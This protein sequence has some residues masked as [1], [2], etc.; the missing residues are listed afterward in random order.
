MTKKMRKFLR[1]LEKENQY[2]FFLLQKFYYQPETILTKGKKEFLKKDYYD[3]DL[4]YK[5]MFNNNFLKF[6]ELILDDEDFINRLDYYM[7]ESLHIMLSKT[8]EF[9]TMHKT[10]ENT[11]SL[12]LKLVKSRI[13]DRKMYNDENIREKIKNYDMNLSKK[14]SKTMKIY[15]RI[16]YSSYITPKKDKKEVL[17]IVKND[18]YED[19][20]NTFLYVNSYNSEK[21]I[22][23]LYC[24]NKFLQIIESK[25]LEL[26]LDENIIEN[27]IHI[28]IN[29]INIKTKN[30]NNMS[31]KRIFDRIDQNCIKNFN[32]E[33]AEELIT[34]LDEKIKQQ[35]KERKV[36]YL[37]DRKI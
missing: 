1:E 37:I 13:I 4:I 22:R 33:K 29:S 31:D 32:I 6:L 34:L 7:F 28:L 14:M 3:I 25:L 15:S 26:H 27:I 23:G 18:N 30:F 8:E 24:E 5:Y 35:K 36:I 12:L 10:K 11:N 19:Y 9:I 21:V 17:E 16:K 20:F 2:E